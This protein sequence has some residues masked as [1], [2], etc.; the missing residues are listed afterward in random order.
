MAMLP[1]KLLTLVFVLGRGRVL[2][3]M[4]KRGFGEGKWNGFGGK[5]E[6]GESLLGCARRELLEETALEAP[7]EAFRERGFMSFLMESDGMVDSAS[8][9]VS[10]V[11]HVFVYSV[12][13]ENCAG[14]PTE[15]EEMRPQWFEHQAVPYPD[16]W[17][18]DKVWLPRVL[19]DDTGELC[20][21][22]DFTFESE[23]AL[24][25]DWRLWEW[26][27]SAA[28]AQG[29]DAE[30][31]RGEPGS[32]CAPAATGAIEEG[33]TCPHDRSMADVA[34]LLWPGACEPSA[35][36]E[37]LAVKGSQISMSEVAAGEEIEGGAE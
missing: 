29:F 22:A 27:S 18:D 17:L 25:D 4:K 34:Q 11:L 33:G 36:I 31:E 2:L 7:E 14:E 24:R 8:G 30:A 13:E 3:G 37:G 20:F 35:E 12:A 6:P 21:N 1:P 16:M 23:G 10:K 26:P 9:A 28:M 19:A 32:G 15:S 5:K